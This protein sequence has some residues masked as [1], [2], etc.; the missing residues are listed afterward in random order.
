MSAWEYSLKARSRNFWIFLSPYPERC[1]PSFYPDDVL[2]RWE[3]PHLPGRKTE[4]HR[5]P[6]T[7]KLESL[8][9]HSSCGNW[10]LPSLLGARHCSEG[11]FQPHQPHL[12]I[13]GRTPPGSKGLREGEV[14]G[15][16][17]LPST[18]LLGPRPGAGACLVSGGSRAVW[19][20]HFPKPPKSLI[21]GLLRGDGAGSD[22]A[23]LCSAA[24]SGF[25]RW[26]WGGEWF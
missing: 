19:G 9:S 15:T 10:V 4:A 5:S 2:A 21:L 11:K 23:P 7:S 6:T 25:V 18:C 1:R 12:S 20:A 24:R 16:Q 17:W 14:G 8:Q 22:L 13:W 3:H 26:G